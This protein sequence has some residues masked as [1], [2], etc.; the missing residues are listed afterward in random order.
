M[1][2]GEYGRYGYSCVNNIK[3]NYENMEESGKPYIKVEASYSIID[4]CNKSSGPKTCRG[5]DL[6]TS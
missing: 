4:H 3:V 5:E 2:L 1:L 6:V